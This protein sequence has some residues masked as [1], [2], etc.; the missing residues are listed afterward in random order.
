VIFSPRSGVGGGLLNADQHFGHRRFSSQILAFSITF[1]DPP[2]WLLLAPEAR[3]WELA[4]TISGTD[5][6]WMERRCGVVGVTLKAIRACFNSPF[7]SSYRVTCS[8]EA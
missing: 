6:S 7:C 4:G 1:L 2:I 8:R 5:L 3:F